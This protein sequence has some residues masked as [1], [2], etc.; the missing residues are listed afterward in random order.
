VTEEHDHIV[1]DLAAYALEA[2][3]GPE[4]THVEAHLATCA[5]C[6]HRLGEYRAVVGALPLV[7]EPATPPAAAWAAIRAAVRKRRPAARGRPMG[8]VLADW[9]PVVRWPALAILVGGLLVWN[10]SLQWQLTHPPYGPEVEALS[11]RPGRIVIFAGTG[12]PGASARL[13]VAVDG[14]HGHLAV[15]G[16]RPLP[17]GRTYQLWFVQTGDRTVTGATFG[18]DAR[19]RAWVK[20]AVPASFPEARAIVIT[21]EPAP[22]SMAPTGHHLL[23]AKAW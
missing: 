13:F 21:E 15:S 7:L 18:V 1:G 19:E 9:L 14:G 12:T 3:E 17:P 16:L 20:V 22:E 10:V 6:A 4:R 8:V 23:E 5:T 2:L 11:R